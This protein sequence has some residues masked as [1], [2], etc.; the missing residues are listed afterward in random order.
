[1]MFKP[2][3]AI[4]MVLL[5]MAAPACRHVGP[6]NHSG[7]QQPDEGPAEL[8]LHSDQLEAMR[9]DLQRRLALLGAVEATPPVAAQ[10]RRIRAALAFFDR[11]DRIAE[12]R[13]TPREQERAAIRAYAGFV[14]VV[15]ASEEFDLP[16]A[17]RIEPD[18]PP[19]A[20]QPPDLG[21][22]F[23]LHDQ[24]DLE[25]ALA[26]GYAVL[27]TFQSVGLES[28]SLRFLLG[29]WALEL[30]DGVLAEEQFEVVVGAEGS[31]ALL[32]ARAI[33]GLRAARALML[34][35]DAAALADARLDLDQGLLRQA[36]ERLA[37][38]LATGTE[39]EVLR[40]AEALREEVRRAAEE[41]AQTRLGRA[42]ALLSGPGP[43]DPVG[44]L[45]AEVRQ[46]PEGTWD[47]D[48]ERRLRAWLLGLT[49][50]ATDP[51]VAADRRA[52]EELLEEARG[53]VAAADYR[54]ALDLYARLDGTPLQATGRREA[55]EA[56]D[57]FVKEERERAARMFV[58]ARKKPDAGS[59]LDAM[60][61]VRDLLAGLLAEFP[62]SGY[63]DRVRGNLDV[64]VEELIKEGFEPPAE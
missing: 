62:D 52:E 49:A 37:E 25:G 15:V 16:D 17:G 43:Y 51:D 30:G 12:G 20:L 18:G 4:A 33:E 6:V 56:A 23:A 45:L 29:T 38:L 58:A 64:V 8:G 46:L 9:G 39:Q 19:P 27:D 42:D 5:L 14:E 34:G 55:A 11:L 1:M 50:G 41:A 28:T 47:A 2:W 32:I 40:Q 44:E 60:I 10:K 26:E 54:A 57:V 63:A 3:P 61:A 35:P 53:L 21:A 22:A 59:R 24:G 48:E 13:S 31:E 36:D 7:N